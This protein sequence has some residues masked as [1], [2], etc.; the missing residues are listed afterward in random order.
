M[1]VFLWSV[2]FCVLATQ[3]QTKVHLTVA[4]EEKKRKDIHISGRGRREKEMVVYL[5]EYYIH[6]PYT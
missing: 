2:I 1:N 5:Y 6:T 3:Q 4:S